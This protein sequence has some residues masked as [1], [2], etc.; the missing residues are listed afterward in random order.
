MCTGIRR[1]GSVSEYPHSFYP[2]CCYCGVKKKTKQR[3]VYDWMGIYSITNEHTKKDLP[4]IVIDWSHTYVYTYDDLSLLSLS[5]RK[6]RRDL[7]K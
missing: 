4:Y 2:A 7:E 1:I 3:I 5:S 6:N